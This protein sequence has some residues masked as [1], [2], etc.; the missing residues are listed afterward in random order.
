MRAIMHSL[1]S[2][3]TLTGKVI[4][5]LAWTA[6]SYSVVLNINKSKSLNFPVEGSPEQPNLIK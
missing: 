1:N 5:M 4:E 6:V 2:R 3:A